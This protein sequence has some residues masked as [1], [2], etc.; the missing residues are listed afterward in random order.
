MK[1]IYMR[2]GRRALRL[3]SIVSVK[4]TPPFLLQ[5][6]PSLISFRLRYL[7]GKLPKQI[8]QSINRR[9]QQPHHCLKRR[10]LSRTWMT[11]GRHE[12][13]RPL[14]T[15]RQIIRLLCLARIG[16]RLLQRRQITLL[17]LLDVV[18]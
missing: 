7:L 4:Q 16:E 14:E 11:L 12:H 13:L 1:N 10:L 17:F 15:R 5:P 2:N 6:P 3:R 9:N 18:R 8:P